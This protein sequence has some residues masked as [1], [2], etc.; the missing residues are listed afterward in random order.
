MFNKLFEHRNLSRDVLG[1]AL[2]A[3]GAIS[4]LTLLG[5]NAGGLML[6]W[7]NFL[8]GAVGIGGF[9]IALGLMALAA[10]IWL[11]SSFKASKGLFLQIIGMEIAFAAFLALIHTIFAGADEAAFAQARTG[12]GA[13]G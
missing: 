12:G 11:G 3:L 1:L 5:I 7:A 2:F 13:V 4:I 8:R 10:P 9:A 6:L